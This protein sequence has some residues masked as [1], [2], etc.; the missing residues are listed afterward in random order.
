VVGLFLALLCPASL[1]V[2]FWWGAACLRL[3]SIIALPERLVAGAAFFGLGLG[4]VLDLLLLRRWVRG[5][6]T[7]R[8]LLVLAV[9]L[10]WSGVAMGLFMGLPVGAMFVGVLFGVYMGRRQ[11]HAAASASERETV[12]GRVALLTALAV[13]LMSLP[14]GL[15]SMHEPDVVRFLVELLRTDAATFHGLSGV[16]I[17]SGLCF[18]LIAVQFYCSLIAVHLAACLHPPTP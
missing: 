14:I 11:F 6:Y 17:V 5:F 2:A 4:L 8:M 9:Y 16:L 18:A 13:G 3:A 7:A 1:F 10:F 12:A 15:L